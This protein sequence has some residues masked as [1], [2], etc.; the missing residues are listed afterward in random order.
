[1]MA[2]VLLVVY[3]FLFT[4][5]KAFEDT[6]EYEE[7]IFY[8][9]RFREELR[10][11]GVEPG[12]LYAAFNRRQGTEFNA[13][14][15]VA[16]AGGLAALTQEGQEQCGELIDH[17]MANAGLIREGLGRIGIEAHGGD[18]SPFVWLRAP[19]GMDSWDFF[20]KSLNEANVVGTP[21]SGFG[22]SGE[23]Y[24]RLSAFGSRELVEDG[25]NRLET[26]LDL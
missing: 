13:A 20:D 25:M 17:Y 8:N 26:R 15:N 12:K 7:Q 21:G 18:N 16:Q 24:F 19:N 5:T 11:R 4:L 10:A 14:C 23:G 9:Q 6:D 3:Y 1:M 2:A 22:P